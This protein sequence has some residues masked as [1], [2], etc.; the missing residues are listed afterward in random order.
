MA[1]AALPEGP[2]EAESAPPGRSTSNAAMLQTIEFVDSLRGQ[3][4][5]NLGLDLRDLGIVLHLVRNHV[6]GRLTTMACLAA[7]SGLSYGTAFRAIEGLIGSGLIVRRPRTATGR[8]FSLHPSSEL[9]RR[10]QLFAGHTRRLIEQIASDVSQAVRK[11]AADMAAVIAPP[12]VLENKLALPRGLRLLVHA[13]PTFMAM[14]ALKRQ[15]EMILG[16]PIQSKALSIDRLWAEIVQNGQ[17]PVSAYDIIA[18]DLP[19]FGDMVGRNRLRPLDDLIAGSEMDMADFLPDAVV[20]AR[21]RGRQYGIPLLSTAEL[22]AYRTDLLDDAGLAP[23]RTTVETLAVARALHAPE[24]GRFGIAWN[25]GRGTALG[26]TFMVAMA[27][28]GQ[29]I[30]NLGQTADGFLPEDMTEDH[31]RPMFDSEAAHAAADYLTELLAVSP[32]DILS[33]TWYDRARAY[34]SGHTSLAYAHTLLVTL[35]ESD[36]A[37]PAYRKTGYVP[38]PIGLGGRPISPLGGYALALP[39]NIAP[40]RVAP[41]WAAL[42]ALTS[43]SAAKLFMTNGSLASP[44]FSVNR[45]PE[46]QALSPVIGVVDAIARKGVLRAWPRP[47]VPGI[48]ALIAIAGEEIHDMLSGLKT[49]AVALATAQNRAEAVMRGLDRD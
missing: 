21:R 34:A 23:P 18:C 29:P 10:W 37:S 24:R 4:S 43:A 19:W 31:L 26:H 9:L 49:R 13:D 1:T 47:P 16:V 6:S 30:V 36:P 27:A 5:E 25:G 35:F 8:S 17:R 42:A 14:N 38:Q 41:A 20:S 12:T 44:R 28:H 11:P 32:P 40:E 39:S 33:M 22:L 45:D 15:F 48:S 2:Y 3:G 46:V 7:A